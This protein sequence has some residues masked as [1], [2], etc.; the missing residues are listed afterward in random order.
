M[1]E[2]RLS[3]RAR[4]DLNDIWLY[5]ASDSPEAA[6]RFIDRLLAAGKKLAASPRIGRAREELARGVRSFP[7]GSYVIF[8][9]GSR[10]GIEVVRI[11]SGYR[12]IEALFGL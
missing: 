7:V 6:D 9:R 2:A 12:D 5:I 10:S 4:A 11:L 3:L 1:K 8:Y